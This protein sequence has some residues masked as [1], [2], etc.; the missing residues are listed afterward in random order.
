VD[1]QG[2]YLG[3][4]P[5][6]AALTCSTA[7][8][9]EVTQLTASGPAPPP[10][11]PAG[12]AGLKFCHV[13]TVNGMPIEYELQVGTIRMRASTG[14]CMPAPGMYCLGIAAGNHPLVLRDVAANTQVLSDSVQIAGGTNYVFS[15]RT[16]PS[17]PELQSLNGNP[18]MCAS[19]DPN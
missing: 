10:P 15:V 18:A 11:T 2:V 19:Y 1:A 3:G 16:T 12:N 5:M 8:A 6:G 4:G 7:T 13:V 17:G 14:Q 9:S